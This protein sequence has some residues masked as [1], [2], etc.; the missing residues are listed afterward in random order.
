MIHYDEIGKYYVLLGVGY[1]LMTYTMEGL[2]KQAK[3]LYNLDVLTIL[4]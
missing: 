1:S 2:Q 4:N 3:E